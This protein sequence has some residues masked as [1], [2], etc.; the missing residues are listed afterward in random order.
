[1]AMTPMNMGGVIR[2]TFTGTTTSSGNIQV[3]NTT[4]RNIVNAYI[5]NSYGS[6]SYLSSI[7]KHSN[8]EYYAHISTFTGADVASTT[9]KVIVYYIID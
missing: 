7:F 4:R 6:T 5:D 2:T 9:V 3:S 8:G 1:M